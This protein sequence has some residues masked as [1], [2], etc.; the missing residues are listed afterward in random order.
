M[1][2]MGRLVTLS[3]LLLAFICL[4]FLIFVVKYAN[5][6]RDLITK[7]PLKSVAGARTSFEK[8]V[9][10]D[11]GEYADDAKEQVMNIR[12][13]DLINPVMRIGK[14]SDDINWVKEYITKE[15]SKTLKK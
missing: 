14:V 12:I 8:E 13:K 6:I 3:K 10:K 2:S 15:V 7:S 11:I 5:E 9:S 1:N 4:I